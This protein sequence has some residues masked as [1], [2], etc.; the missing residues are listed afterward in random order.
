MCWCL[1]GSGRNIELLDGETTQNLPVSPVLAT[2]LCIAGLLVFCCCRITPRY[3]NNLVGFLWSKFI[4]DHR[5][6]KITSDSVSTIL[7]SAVTIRPRETS[8]EH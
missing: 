2:S 3:N 6:C 8:V 4:S 5:Q 7:T 1:V